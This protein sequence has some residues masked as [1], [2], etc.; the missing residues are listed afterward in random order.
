MFQD[1][2]ISIDALPFK[3]EKKIL[4]HCSCSFSLLLS[5]SWLLIWDSQ[6]A[7]NRESQNQGADPQPLHVVRALLNS[8]KL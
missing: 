7:F 1:E 5:L 4:W 8:L 3:K 2:G 6:Q